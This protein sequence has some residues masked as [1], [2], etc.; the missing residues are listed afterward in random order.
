MKV[1]FIKDL[2]SKT[3]KDDIKEVSSGYATNFLFPKKLAIPMSQE[4][5]QEI[6][7]KKL[8]NQKDIEKE[9]ES[10]EKFSKKIQ[11]LQ[12]VI[13]EKANDEGHLFGSVDSNE[14]SK[15]LKEKFK[16]DLDKNKIDLPHHIKELGEHKVAI[17]LSNDETPFLKITINRKK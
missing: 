12:I 10:I 7:S 16:I 6:K 5:I 9:K 1:I 3:R 15:I 11:S 17:K 13:E 2:D 14:I 8:K 4:K